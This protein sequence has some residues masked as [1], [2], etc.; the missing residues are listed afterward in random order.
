MTIEFLELDKFYS[1]YYY[2]FFNL[3]DYNIHRFNNN[4]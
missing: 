4:Q 2:F 1:N 3:N